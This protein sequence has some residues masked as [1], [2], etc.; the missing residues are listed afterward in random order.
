MYRN[1]E[2][3]KIENI[4][5]NQANTPTVAYDTMALCIHIQKTISS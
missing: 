1:N 4:Y 5:S 2:E 3:K